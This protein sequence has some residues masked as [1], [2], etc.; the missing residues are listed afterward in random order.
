MANAICR[1][2]TYNVS[3]ES[4]NKNTEGLTE[5]PTHWLLQMAVPASSLETK[6]MS[7]EWLSKPHF[8][9]NVH[10]YKE[11]WRSGKSPQINHCKLLSQLQF[12]A[13]VLQRIKGMQF[14]CVTL[15]KCPPFP[16][17]SLFALLYGDRSTA[18]QKRAN[19]KSDFPTCTKQNRKGYVK[20]L[21][22][23][24]VWHVW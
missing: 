14:I 9:L 15:P 4:S 2:M 23:N 21:R 10:I 17:N 20:P 19:N 5:F 1:D 18:L 11:N 13:S 24:I 3:H 16:L 12:W 6:R 22:G 7:S 8:S